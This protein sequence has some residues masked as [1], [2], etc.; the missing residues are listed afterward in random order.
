MR[1]CDYLKSFE[2]CV[3]K[4]S[5]LTIASRHSFKLLAAVCDMNLFGVFE[6]FRGGKTLKT[7]IHVL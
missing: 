7:P 2:L 3:E 6:R 4:T 5:L 1:D